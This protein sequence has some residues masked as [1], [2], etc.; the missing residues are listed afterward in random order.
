MDLYVAASALSCALLQ[1][2]KALTFEARSG[3][4]ANRTHYISWFKGRQLTEVVAVSIGLLHY[5]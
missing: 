4:D 2:I 1:L 3:S 5:T